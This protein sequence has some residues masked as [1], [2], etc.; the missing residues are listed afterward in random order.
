MMDLISSAPR[1][2][3][4]GETVIGTDF[5]TAPGGKGINQAVQCARLGAEVTMAGCVGNDAFGKE[6]LET[7]QKSGVDVSKVKITDKK[8]SGVGNIQLEVKED[9][10][11]NRI[12]VVPGANYELSVQDLAWLE[13]EIKEYDLLMLQ[14]ELLP[15]T[16]EYAAKC[17]Y[18][19]GVPVMLNPAPAAELSKDLLRCVT[20]LSPNEYE[21]ALLSGHK[22]DA[23]TEGVNLND[24]K[25]VTK[26][27]QDK[28]VKKVMVT[29]GSNGS[30]LADGEE[31]KFAQCVKME[32]VKDPTA[33]GDS[34][35]AAF[36]TGITAGITEENALAFA[37][38]TAAITVSGMGAMPSL[39]TIEQV[40]KLLEERNFKEIDE[41]QLKILK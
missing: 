4:M 36:C 26:L 21:A 32:H 2:P 38:H 18:N 16:T 1:V 7:A 20:Y 19:A 33:A 27:L 10:V 39:P 34:F 41:E 24:L 37:S 5:Q 31:L 6:M 9:S 12:L 13:D 8:S 22:L 29:L 14:L 17:A 15:E 40:E 25:E 35:V 11:Q 30:V 23:D 3:D 28:G